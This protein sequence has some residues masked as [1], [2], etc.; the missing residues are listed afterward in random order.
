MLKVIFIKW[1]QFMLMSDITLKH[2]SKLSHSKW[3]T[4]YP[5]DLKKYHVFVFSHRKKKIGQKA[6]EYLEYNTKFKGIKIREFAHIN[7]VL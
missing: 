4:I 1:M 3:P 2:N 7:F 6:K 5:R